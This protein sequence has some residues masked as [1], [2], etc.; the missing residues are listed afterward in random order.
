MEPTLYE[1]QTFVGEV[2]H[3]FTH[4][5]PDLRKLDYYKRLEYLKLWSLEERWN[6]ADLIEAFKLHKGLTDVPYTTFFQ[7]AADSSTRGHSWKISNLANLTARP[8]CINYFFLY[9]VINRWNSLPEEAIQVDSI[10]SFKRHLQKIYSTRMGFFLDL[11]S[12][13]SFFITPD[14]S[15]KTRKN[16]AV[17][18]K[19]TYNYRI[20]IKRKTTKLPSTTGEDCSPITN[21]RCR[22]VTRTC[23]C[24]QSYWLL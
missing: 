2:Q 5:F 19:N 20:K 1:G 18:M 6:R 7:L 16:T 23:V 14:G 10:N 21:W 17:K 22:Q 4:L 8:I 13:Q 12:N 3:R 15:T 9:K 11:T 24:H